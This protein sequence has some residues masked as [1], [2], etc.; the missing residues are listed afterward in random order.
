MSEKKCNLMTNYIFVYGTL[1]LKSLRRE[2]L[3][4][5]TLS[6]PARL[7]GFTTGSVLLDDI[8]YPI[9]TKNPD[10]KET[11]EGEYFAV[12]EQDLEKLDAYE[13]SAYRRIKVELENGIFALVYIK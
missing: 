9:I 4:H 10:S 13:S 1:R 12:D 2:I 3:G 5:E 8:E 11:I 6:V 7:K